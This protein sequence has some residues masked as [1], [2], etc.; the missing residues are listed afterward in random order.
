MLYFVFTSVIL[1]NLLIAMMTRTYETIEEVSEEVW[2]FMMHELISEYVDKPNVPAPF[3]FI[4]LFL[5]A[6]KEAVAGADV[7]SDSDEHHIDQKLSAA[8]EMF[9]ESNTDTFVAK[10]Q[11][12]GEHSAT[13]A[14][15]KADEM[16]ERQDIMI[17]GLE[18]SISDMI[19]ASEINLERRITSSVKTTLSQDIRLLKDQLLDIRRAIPGY[20]EKSENFLSANIIAQDASVEAAVNG[21]TDSIGIWEARLE[22]MAQTRRKA[23]ATGGKASM[24]R[25]VDDMLEGWFY[26]YAGLHP[27]VSETRR[28]YLPSPDRN[29]RP[30]WRNEFETFEID[31]AVILFSYNS[32]SMT[33]KHCN[34]NL[35]TLYEAEHG[36]LNDTIQNAGEAEFLN[37]I[38]KPRDSS[39]KVAMRLA[40]PPPLQSWTADWPFGIPYDPPSYTA[41]YI[42]YFGPD[43]P[44]IAESE[45]WAQS[46]DV[47]YE[48]QCG[49][50]PRSCL[51]NGMPRNPFGRTGLRGRGNLGSWGPNKARHYLIHRWK[52]G[53]RNSPMRR[54]ERPM[55]EVLVCKQPDGIWQLPGG[56]QADSTKLDPTLVDALG[57]SFAERDEHLHALKTALLDTKQEALPTVRIRHDQRNT[58]NAWVEAKFLTVDWTAVNGNV[59]ANLEIVEN[60]AS[61]RMF[62]WAVAHRSLRCWPTHHAAI[63][64]VVLQKGAFW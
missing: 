43:S 48:I 9:Q 2:H 8:L 36:I 56:F 12:R 1:T 6:A 60:P 20:D 63:Y 15:E 16:M 50:V 57:L 31:G 30:F 32:A 49:N 45:Q 41:P 13:S 42:H 24:V 19:S 14:S 23:K 40:V 44:A 55:L 29:Y 11:E 28:A 47:Q 25:V 51:V 21:M 33:K 39:G 27:V 53:S 35:I 7:D 54:M 3:S 10:M 59:N 58:D 46:S 34:Q 64:E 18:T 52:F 17:E 5:D 38:Q 26:E 62:A 37:A 22:D 4:W 61:D